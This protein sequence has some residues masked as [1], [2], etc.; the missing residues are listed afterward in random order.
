VNGEDVEA[1][2]TKIAGAGSS[3]NRV[4]SDAPLDDD[5]VAEHLRL[6][7]RR[8]PNSGGQPLRFRYRVVDHEAH[9]PIGATRR[10]IQAVLAD[11]SVWSIDE[12]DDESFTM[13][14]DP[15][16]FFDP[17]LTKETLAIPRLQSPEVFRKRYVR[18][19]VE[20]LLKEIED[21]FHAGHEEFL[22][23]INA[24]RSTSEE[25][26]DEVVT[27]ARTSGWIA[28]R[29]GASVSIRMPPAR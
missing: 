3:D 18:S 6:W 16:S 29:R 20:A 10:L 28:V 15:R 17:E 4:S 19:Q 21:W 14:F 27:I 23:N 8:Q 13:K 7:T 2:A 22:V 5:D 26:W 11:S 9:V 1:I 24:N 25:T 12:F